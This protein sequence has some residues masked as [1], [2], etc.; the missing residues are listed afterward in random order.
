VGY[1]FR[2]ALAA[3]NCDVVFRFF[4]LLL[5]HA[6]FSPYELAIE[7]PALLGG[8]VLWRAAYA[9]RGGG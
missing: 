5:F 7:V 1:A 4:G 2:A 6:T 3:A 8:L 9:S